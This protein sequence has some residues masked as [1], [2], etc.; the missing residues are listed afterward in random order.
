MSTA[1]AIRS[2]TPL[3]KIHSRGSKCID[4]SVGSI[5][6]AGASDAATL[7]RTNWFSESTGRKNDADLRRVGTVLADVAVDQWLLVH[8]D[9]RTLPRVRNVMDALVALFHEQRAPLEGRAA[10]TAE[11]S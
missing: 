2:R 7:C 10:R 6:G 9:L 8:R 11:R 5:R 4:G 3:V 1:H